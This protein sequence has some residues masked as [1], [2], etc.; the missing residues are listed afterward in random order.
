VLQLQPS[1]AARTS[2]TLLQLGE[3]RCVMICTD[4][5]CKHCQL[6]HFTAL[7]ILVLVP[8]CVHA[9]PPRLLGLQFE[10]C[11]CLHARQHMSKLQQPFHVQPCGFL[12]CPGDS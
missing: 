12:G 5:T 2:L 9:P 11:W 10:L 6:A 3:S 7:D 8:A 4:A 1:N